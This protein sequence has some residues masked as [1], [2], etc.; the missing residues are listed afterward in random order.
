MMAVHDE[1]HANRDAAVLES[2]EPFGVLGWNRGGRNSRSV[3]RVAGAP[4]MRGA[5]THHAHG[6]H[7]HRHGAKP[8]GSRWSHAAIR[9]RLL[10]VRERFVVDNDAPADLT[11]PLVQLVEA[12]YDEHVR[13]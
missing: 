1:T 11:A 6:A 9:H 4:C 8:R 5:K 3:R 2:L 10:V 12:S 13:L 7:Q